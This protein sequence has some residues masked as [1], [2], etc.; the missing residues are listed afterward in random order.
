M[1]HPAILQS[2]HHLLAQPGNTLPSR[3]RRHGAVHSRRGT[4]YDE[5]IQEDRIETNSTVCKK[6]QKKSN[7]LLVH[8]RDIGKLG[9][10]L[11]YERRNPKNPNTE[12][13]RSPKKKATHVFYFAFAIFQYP[14]HGHYIYSSIL[15]KATFV[16]RHTRVGLCLCI[17][18]REC[19]SG[20]KKEFGTGLSTKP[21]DGDWKMVYTMPLFVEGNWVQMPDG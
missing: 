10:E 2:P 6:D 19:H 12:Y 17:I 21:I 11:T 20:G 18:C 9:V 7:L 1:I 8:H 3:I 13:G 4:P 16:S 15:V 14:I 5:D